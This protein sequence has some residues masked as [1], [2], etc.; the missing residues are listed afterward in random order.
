[1][2]AVLLGF[3]GLLIAAD[4]ALLVL[5]SPVAVRQQ[6]WRLLALTA[7]TTGLIAGVVGAS[8]LGIADLLA[9][10]QTPSQSV[11]ALFEGGGIFGAPGVILGALWW[12]HSSILTA[13]DR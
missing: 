13:V 9:G 12:A 11:F 6:S 1:V 4:V 3:V 8:Y 2:S 5:P 7:L 10:M